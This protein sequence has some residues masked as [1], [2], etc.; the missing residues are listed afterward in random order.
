M[1]A[2]PETLTGADEFLLAMAAKKQSEVYA[3]QL[4]DSEFKDEARG[5]QATNRGSTI[6]PERVDGRVRS[7]VC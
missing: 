2:E 5:S 7:G 3:I 4:T 6:A 1:A